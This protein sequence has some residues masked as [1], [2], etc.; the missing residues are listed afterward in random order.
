MATVRAATVADSAAIAGVHVRSWRDA[1]P[2][3][4]PDEVLAGLDVDTR[5]RDHAARIAGAEPN[6][7]A[8][9]VATDGDD[10]VGFAQCGPYRIDRHTVEPG[11][12]EVYAIYVDPPALGTGVGAALMSA[13]LGWAAGR[14]FSGVR[15]WV[16][17]DNTRARAFYERFGFTP[18]GATHH[19]TAGGIDLPEV[20]YARPLDVT[21]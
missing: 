7:W 11:V 18:D 16:L 8:T 17:R 5:A 6:G 21:G 12:G 2:G 13:S 1:Y 10:V 3:I 20:R 15:L 9:L 4:V 19:Y 14:T